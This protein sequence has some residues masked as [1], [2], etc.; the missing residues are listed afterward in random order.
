ME[1]GL[2]VEVVEDRFEESES[3]LEAAAEDFSVLV[4][5]SVGFS[6]VFP[7]FGST[8]PAPRA[9]ESLFVVDMGPIDRLSATR[10]KHA[11][12]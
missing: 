1:D 7:A 3:E 12:G 6:V 8:S 10:G 2:G 11:T 4:D 9:P 5:R